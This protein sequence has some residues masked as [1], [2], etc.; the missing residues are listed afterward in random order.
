MA[1]LFIINKITFHQGSTKNTLFAIVRFNPVDVARNDNNSAIASCES[2][3][4][5]I[6]FSLFSTL[7]Y[8]VIL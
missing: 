6:T 8:P 7:I 4:Y 1:G 2:L 5:F 3:N